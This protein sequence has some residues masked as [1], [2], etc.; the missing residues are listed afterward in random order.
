MAPV[1]T[2]SPPVPSDSQD[3][4]HRGGRV[5]IYMCSH[6]YVGIYMYVYIYIW[7]P[8]ALAPLWCFGLRVHPNPNPNPQVVKTLTNEEAAALAQLAPA[9]AAHFARHPDSLINRFLGQYRLYLYGRCAPLLWLYLDAEVLVLP[10][11]FLP[12]DSVFVGCRL[13]RHTHPFP[14]SSVV[15]VWPV[16]PR[17]SVIPRAVSLRVSIIQSTGIFGIPLPALLSNICEIPRK[18]TRR[19]CGS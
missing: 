5:G 6:I 16:P 1:G 11:V 12:Q 19:F 10:L 18:E 15:L 7:H 14:V 13:R 2:C 4:H 17:V 3:A 9:F 8:L